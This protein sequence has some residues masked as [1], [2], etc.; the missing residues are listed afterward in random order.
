MATANTTVSKNARPTVRSGEFRTLLLVD[1]S[2]DTRELY[3]QCFEF[4]GWSVNEASDGRDA[5]AKALADTP[6]LVVTEVRLPFIDGAA[7]CELL[8]AE[9]STSRVPILIITAEHR[10]AELE[11]VRR[12]GANAVL[13]KPA[14]PDLVVETAT[15]LLAQPIELAA[16]VTVNGAVNASI[17]VS[18]PSSEQRHKPHSKSFARFGTTRARAAAGPDVSVVRQ[19]VEVRVQPGG[20]RE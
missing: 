12:A 13:T 17:I 14:L 16:C 19:A 5:L 4:A 2:A 7:L 20:P 10:P 3:R 6:S 18:A 8:R 15:S 1:P 11:R 9:P